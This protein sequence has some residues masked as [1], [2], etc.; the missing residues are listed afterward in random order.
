MATIDAHGRLLPAK[1]NVL[2][3]YHYFHAKD[4]GKY[5]LTPE[6]PSIGI[7]HVTDSALDYGE[8]DYDIAVVAKKVIA[9]IRGGRP[10]CAQLYTG[11]DGQTAQIIK[12]T[13]ATMGTEGNV[14]FL[15]KKHQA[16]NLALQIEWHSLGAVRLN[17]KKYGVKK[18]GKPK[19]V[20]GPDGTVYV[21]YSTNPQRA[22]LRREGN[23][24]W[25]TVTPAQ[26]LSVAEI[27]LA[28]LRRWPQMNPLDL[29]HG[30]YEIGRGGHVD[31]GPCVIEALHEIGVKYLGLP[32]GFTVPAGVI[33][34]TPIVVSAAP[35]A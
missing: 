21:R 9:M 32:K 14:I 23:L 29:L 3:V 22:D 27:L 10:Y 15:G 19:D 24:L 26:T 7:H 1:N 12:L 31:P 30:H 17:G 18:D 34:K 20:K 4:Y 11:R 25:Q 2:K 8:D 6:A 33:M 13:R 5:D 35:G 28:A 16:N